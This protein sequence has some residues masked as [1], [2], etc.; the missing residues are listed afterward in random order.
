MTALTR[1][2]WIA[3]LLLTAA[4]APAQAQRA[5]LDTPPVQPVSARN[6]M[7]V[8]QEARAARIGADV[9]QRGGNAV[10]AAVAVGFALA[11]TYPRAGNIGGGGFMVIHLAA[12]GRRSIAI[13]YRE[14]APSATTRETYLD[15]HG[16]ADPQQVARHR[17]CHR[18]ARHGCGSVAGAPEIRLGTFH[19][20]GV[21][22]AGARARPRR[23]FRSTTISPIRCRAS[24]A[25]LA[26]WP[27]SA[28]IFL[29]RWRADRARRP[30]WCRPIL[31]PPSAT[32]PATARARSMMARSPIRSPPPCA[33][34]AG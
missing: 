8:A 27:S 26:R 33:R 29:R 21:D 19:I 31:P 22:R 25:R 9:L 13:D 10:D 11:V 28:K 2:A 15:A 5:S 24:I 30:L 34:P 17:A 1:R 20:R 18:R 32:S 23:L 6:G 14:T 7:V 12:A 4:L 3:G 16:A